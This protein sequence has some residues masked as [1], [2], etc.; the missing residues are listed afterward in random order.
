MLIRML[1]VINAIQA[2]FLAHIPYTYSRKVLQCFHI[3]N[4]HKE[5]VQAMIFPIRSNKCS[6][7]NSMGGS[8]T[9]RETQF[10]KPKKV[11]LR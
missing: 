1:P 3:S 10:V 9:Y 7:H 2:E 11:I 8:F 6:K 4:L 5:S